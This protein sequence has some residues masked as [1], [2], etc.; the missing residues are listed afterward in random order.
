MKPEDFKIVFMG[1]PDF[2]VASLNAIVET[3]FNVVGVITATDK[4]AGRG[5]KIKYSAVKEYALQRELNILQPPNLK[6]PEFNA[7]LKALNADLF[8][9]VA[10]R[11]LPDMVW[12]MP[13]YGT[14][15]L[16]GS[17][18]PQYRGAAPINWAVINGEEKSGAT[19]FFIQKQ[20][21]TG[22][23]LDQVEIS[24][25]ENMTAGELHDE[26]MHIGAECL[27][28]T[29]H[30]IQA[31]TAEGKPQAEF[32]ADELKPAPKIY[33]DTCNISWNGPKEAVHNHIRGLSPFP[34]AWT[35]LNDE[36]GT[37]FKILRSELSPLKMLA[38][39]GTIKA[40]DSELHVATGSGF[41]KITELQMQGKKRM[42]TKVFLNGYQFPENSSYNI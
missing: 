33:R 16:H 23:I 20:I 26:M 34:G 30:S 29:I 5:K 12:Q 4:P 27:V 39:A 14:I 32:S 37:V 21:D 38:P 36:K 11:M 10:F 25:S 2:A 7:E 9:V 3:G 40:L 8:A 13:E 19:T 18:L 42:E 15:N 22:N 6:A 41:V 35:T 31:G 28:N 1:T 24:I 17:L